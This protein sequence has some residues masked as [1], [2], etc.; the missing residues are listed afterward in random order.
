MPL[1]QLALRASKAS[2]GDTPWNN[3]QILRFLH[4]QSERSVECGHI[5]GQNRFSLTGAS[6]RLLGSYESAVPE[7][8]IGAT[9]TPPSYGPGEPELLGH[10]QGQVV[11]RRVDELRPHPSY[12]RHQIAVPVPQLSPLIELG[13]LAFQEPILITQDGAILDGYDRW[14][15]ARR[16]GRLTLPCFEFDLPEAEALRWLL[17]K[18]RRSDGLNAFSRIVMAQELEPWLREKARSNKQ[19]GG[20]QKGS[21]NLTEADKLDVRSEIAAVAGAS[22]G[23]V[24][25]VKQLV[26]HAQP[27]LLQALR[28]GEVS[29]HRGWTWLQKP[30]QQLDQLRLHQNLRGIT[31]K[32]ESLLRAHRNSARDEPLGVERILDSLMAMDPKRKTSILVSEME[33]PGEV[34]LI[35]TGLRKALI[36]QGELQG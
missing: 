26:L 1:A 14:M 36:S 17:Q 34:L 27:A 4:A 12:V 28:D 23:N 7:A 2:Y 16:Q 13:E 3:R 21:S 18:H 30:G 15:L 10:V 5:G 6:V 11:T 20:Q 32:V 22:T 8:S 25:K 33:I 35:S 31:Q 24:S 9:G 29:I 19:A